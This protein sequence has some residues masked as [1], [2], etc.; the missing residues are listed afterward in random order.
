MTKYRFT[1]NNWRSLLLYLLFPVPV[2]RILQNYLSSGAAMLIGIALLAVLFI[3]LGKYVDSVVEFK[4][5]FLLFRKGFGCKEVKINY[6][7]IKKINFSHDRFLELW[8][9]TA[10]NK[11]KIPPPSNKLE[12][13]QE[14]FTWLKDQNPAIEIEISK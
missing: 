9:Y 11:I 2:L 4:E 3:L 1:Q 7:D 5:V 6:A 12:K 8:I 10:E 13:A 14:L